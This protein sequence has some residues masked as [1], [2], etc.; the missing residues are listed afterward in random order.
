MKRVCC[1]YIRYKS[2][3]LSKYLCLEDSYIHTLWYNENVHVLKIYKHSPWS[4]Y[5]MIAHVNFANI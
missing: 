1:K 2:I 5:T 3:Y 4:M